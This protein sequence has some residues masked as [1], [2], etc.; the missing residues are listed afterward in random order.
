MR[1]ADLVLLLINTFK[2]LNTN[3][4]E[5]FISHLNQQKTREC[6]LNALTKMVPKV[7]DD[8]LGEEMIGE[9][10]TVNQHLLLSL[11]EAS[12]VNY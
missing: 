9:N 7:N 3:N 8:L 4:L 5:K 12:L 1:G 2:K 11:G 6:Q 10:E